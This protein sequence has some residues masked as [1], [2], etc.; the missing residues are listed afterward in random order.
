M[1]NEVKQELRT[2]FYLTRK[3]EAMLG[4]LRF[5]QE[6]SSPLQR[7]LQFLAQ[8]DFWDWE[9]DN[10]IYSFTNLHERSR[11]W[12]SPDH[13][14]RK[15]GAL[16]VV[17]DAKV[18]RKVRWRASHGRWQRSDATRR[19]APIDLLKEVIDEW[20]A[21]IDSAE[22]RFVAPMREKADRWNIQGARS[23]QHLKKVM[24]KLEDPTGA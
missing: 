21:L 18:A 7:Q 19:V 15:L 4:V 11:T 20:N 10:L 13:A 14:V 22:A 23:L 2:S 1:Q 17:I 3:A 16:G 5:F 6:P 8:N 24:P 12:R 9:I